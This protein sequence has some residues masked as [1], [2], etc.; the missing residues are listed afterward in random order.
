MYRIRVRRRMQVSL[1]VPRIKLAKLTA[2]LIM[3][4]IAILITN[5]R[6]DPSKNSQVCKQIRVNIRLV[7]NFWLFY[8]T[9]I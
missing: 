6:I 2:E 4:L 7:N 8:T 5:L 3:F 1:S 9:G